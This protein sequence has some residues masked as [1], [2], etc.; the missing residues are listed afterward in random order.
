MSQEAWDKVKYGKEEELTSEER[1]SFNRWRNDY[2]NSESL[3]KQVKKDVD[4][5]KKWIDKKMSSDT[6]LVTPRPTVTAFAK[7]DFGIQ[8]LML[9]MMPVLSRRP[10]W[11]AIE[12]WAVNELGLKSLDELYPMITTHGQLF[13]LDNL[14][15]NFGYGPNYFNWANRKPAGLKRRAFTLYLVQIDVGRIASRDSAM[16]WKIGITSKSVT[17][18]SSSKA[19]FHGR[20]GENVRVIKEKVFRDGRD[21]YMVEQTIIRMSHQETHYDRERLGALHEKGEA[22]EA[23]ESLD[24]KTMAELG[25][26]EWIYPCKTEAEVISIF[27]RMTSYGEFH[28][29]G[30]VGYSCFKRDFEK[31]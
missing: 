3:R 15:F 23:L 18:S 16:A 17:G 4:D 1:D 19:R 7:S 22:F 6:N 28:G 29:E 14:I 24:Q 31:H 9:A 25:Y 13:L 10:S 8:C 30:N 21:A 27:E 26:T 5:L 11:M 2:Q 20:V 12:D